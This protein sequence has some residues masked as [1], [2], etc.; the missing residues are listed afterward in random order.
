M[1]L[2]IVECVLCMGMVGLIWVMLDI[3]ADNHHAD[4]SR[5]ECISPDYHTRLHRSVLPS[6]ASQ[7]QHVMVFLPATLIERLRNAAYWAGN[8]PP[9]DLMTEAIDTIV[10]QVEKI[11]GEAF[12]QHVSPLK[13]EAMT[14]SALSGPLR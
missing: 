5:Q 4:D 6:P 8:H 2:V 3:F 9:V 11:N 12:P 10:T 1:T 7:E 14:R 13:Q